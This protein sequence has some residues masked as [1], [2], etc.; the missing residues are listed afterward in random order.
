[1]VHTMFAF[2]NRKVADETV[3]KELKVTKA[4]YRDESTNTMKSPA[5][6][7]TVKKSVRFADSEA[8]I[9]REENEKKLVKGSD[10]FGGIRVKVKMTKEEAS[11]LLSKCKEGGILEFKDVARELVAIPRNRVTVVSALHQ[12]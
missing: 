9:F 11:R 5:H 2:L 1:M 7:K 10:E 4:V 12:R 3:A 6:A 8:S